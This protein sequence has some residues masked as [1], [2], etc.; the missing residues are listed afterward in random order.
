MP[1]WSYIQHNGHWLYNVGRNTDGTLY[2]PN[3]YPEDVVCSAVAAAEERRHQRR[4]TAAKKAGETRRK[5]VATNCGWPYV[6]TSR[7]LPDLRT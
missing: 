4:S 7:D 5:R 3:G 2:N 1:I 6:R